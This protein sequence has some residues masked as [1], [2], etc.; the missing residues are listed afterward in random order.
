MD[1]AD[2]PVIF[3]AIRTGTRRVRDLL[4]D[5]EPALVF[6]TTVKLGSLRDPRFTVSQ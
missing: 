3:L 2:Q 1:A 5:G 6:R 4:Q